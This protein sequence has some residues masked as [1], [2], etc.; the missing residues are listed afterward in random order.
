MVQSSTYRARQMA[1]VRLRQEARRD[2]AWIQLGRDSEAMLDQVSVLTQ[3]LPES[4]REH[5]K[6]QR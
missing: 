6:L 3:D 5:P 2:Q 1:R 4:V